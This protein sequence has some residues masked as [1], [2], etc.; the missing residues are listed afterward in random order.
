M[1][2]PT[3]IAAQIRDALPGWR[4]VPA[5]VTPPDN[6]TAGRIYLQVWRDGVRVDPA[7]VLQILSDVTFRLMVGA[8]PTI[9]ID[10]D[11]ADALDQL[12]T[13]LHDRAAAAS[14]GPWEARYAI[15][16]NNQGVATYPGYE[17][18]F[19]AV[20]APNPYRKKRL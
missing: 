2:L 7:N 4:I 17:I 1:T 14:W 9:A 19:S 12:M 3:D 13:V 5:P 8:T 16:P 11:L 15:F 18:S 6:L 10:Q 20:P